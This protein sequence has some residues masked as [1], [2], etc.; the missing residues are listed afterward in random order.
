MG[1][2]ATLSADNSDGTLPF[3]DDVT[4][5]PGLYLVAIT[6][7]GRLT[8]HLLPEQGPV[9]IGRAVTEDIAFPGFRSLSRQHARLFVGEEL[10]IQNLSRKS[11]TGVRGR[12]L[13]VNEEANINQGEIIQLGPVMVLVKR[14]RS[15]LQA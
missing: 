6:P 11:F 8:S 10:R 13:Q 5:S 14:L 15:P 2:N 4:P 3:E 1:Q 7:D 12:R 9:D